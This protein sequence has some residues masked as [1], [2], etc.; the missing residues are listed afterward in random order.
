VTRAS[1]RPGWD[2]QSG[3]RARRD[4]RGCAAPNYVLLHIGRCPFP[5]L[6]ANEEG[7]AHLEHDL[8]DL[9]QVLCQDQGPIE[10]ATQAMADLL[11]RPWADADAWVEAALASG[12]LPLVH[13]VMI[14]LR[15]VRA[16]DIPELSVWAHGVLRDRVVPAVSAAIAAHKRAL[17]IDADQ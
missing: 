17:G 9:G 13:R 6:R 11:S 16:R 4:H 7:L 14:A 3:D 2:L 8:D 5:L 15:A 10:A 12:S 1:A